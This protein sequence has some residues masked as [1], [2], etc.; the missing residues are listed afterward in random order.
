MAGWQCFLIE[1][2]TLCR[3]S[4]RRYS[5]EKCSIKSIHDVSVVID[6]DLE[7]AEEMAVIQGNFDADPRWPSQCPCGYSFH[8]TDHWQVHSDRLYKGA[9]DGKLYALRDPDLPVGAM[10]NADWLIHAGKGPDDQSLVVRLPG[11]ADWPIDAVLNGRS[12]SRIGTP[13]GITVAPSVNNVGIYHG[14][15][16]GGILTEDVEG[17]TFPGIPRTA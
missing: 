2:T 10:W 9:S 6:P 13:P 3:R 8:E 5:D 11:G 17:R 16:M 7:C 4:F 12:W 15:L 14:S 1:Q